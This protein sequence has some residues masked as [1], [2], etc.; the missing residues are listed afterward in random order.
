MQFAQLNA[1][2][3]ALPDGDAVVHMDGIMDAQLPNVPG[4]V[5]HFASNDGGARILAPSGGA[6]KIGIVEAAAIRTTE[7][8]TAITLACHPGGLWLAQPV[9]TWEPATW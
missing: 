5:Y 3:V 4:R 2:N 9:G 7:S 8:N 1:E 6:I